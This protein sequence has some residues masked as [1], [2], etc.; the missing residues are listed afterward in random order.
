M[1]KQEL[2]FAR[3]IQ[4]SDLGDV[5]ALSSYLAVGTHRIGINEGRDERRGNETNGILSLSTIEIRVR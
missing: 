5:K 2:N 1:R 3:E 4:S